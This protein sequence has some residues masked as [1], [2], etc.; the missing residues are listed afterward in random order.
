[1]NS[2]TTALRVGGTVFG[3]V[4][5]AQLGRLVTGLEVTA[6][7]HVVPMWPSVLA[8]LLTGGLCAWL[9]WLTLKKGEK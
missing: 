2:P 7:G 8:F 4:C 9:W 3:L 6:A 5:L 1:M